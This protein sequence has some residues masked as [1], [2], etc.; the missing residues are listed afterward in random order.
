[1]EGLLVGT[2]G[3]GHPVLGLRGWVAV[4]APDS[5]QRAAMWR[6]V[7]VVVVVVPLRWG[8]DQRPEARVLVVVQ[9]WVRVGVESRGEILR[10]PHPPPPLQ[11]HQGRELA[12][13]L[14]VGRVLVV[15]RTVLRLAHSVR[16][17]RPGMERS[18]QVLARVWVVTR[19]GSQQA[20]AGTSPLQAWHREGGAVRGQVAWMGMGRRHR[21][22]H[23]GQAGRSCLT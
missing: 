3:R 8:P 22:E 6:K 5:H 21:L 4:V 11:L 20:G 12:R 18:A 17:R 23:L 16:S 7:V 10:C 9:V 13:R 19:G 15:H 14:G 2:V 1:M